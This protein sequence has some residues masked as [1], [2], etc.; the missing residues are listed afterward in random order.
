MQAAS[1]ARST[2][3][4]CNPQEQGCLPQAAHNSIKN[5]NKTPNAQEVLS[6]AFPEFGAAENDSKNVFE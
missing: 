4:Y 3:A 5:V 1:Y 6:S 2:D